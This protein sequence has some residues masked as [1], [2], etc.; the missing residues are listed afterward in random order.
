MALAIQPSEPEETT[1]QTTAVT[2]RTDTVPDHG[3]EVTTQAQAMTEPAAEVTAQAQAMVEPPGEVTAQT[4]AVMAR[5]VL[6][7]E[8]SAELRQAV[9][10]SAEAGPAPDEVVECNN[11]FELLVA[12]VEAMNEGMRPG[13]VVLD[14][15]MQILD[16]KNAALMLRG[17]EEAFELDVPTPIVFFTQQPCDEG[18]K[19]L[20]GYLGD[21][22][23]VPKTE[24]EDV[25]SAAQ[26]LLAAIRA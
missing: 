15:R 19:R 10:A 20:L 1:R 6:L 24:G 16:G 5:R 8:P 12:A 4:T 11:G 22:R 26:R 3:N 2:E 13:L 18:L 17:L 9:R 23:H 21:A 14:T 7:A 25:A